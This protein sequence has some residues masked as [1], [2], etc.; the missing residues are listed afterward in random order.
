M[1]RGGRARIERVVI[2]FLNEEAVLSLL[3]K[4]LRKLRAIRIGN[5][6][7]SDGSTDSSV[8]ILTELAGQ[9]P[10]NHEV[11]PIRCDR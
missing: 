11:Y 7:S 8:R 2:P 5:S 9:D 6:S 3:Q 1:L 4:R 10:A